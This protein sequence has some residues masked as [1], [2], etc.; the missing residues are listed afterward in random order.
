MSRD[1]Q[2]R[3]SLGPLS[4]PGGRQLQWGRADRRVRYDRRDAARTRNTDDRRGFLEFQHAVKMLDMPL[5]SLRGRNWLSPRHFPFGAEP[6]E[7]VRGPIRREQNIKSRPTRDSDSREV[8]GPAIASARGA[9][10]AQAA[11]AAMNELSRA[12]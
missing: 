5:M 11:V 8:F 7:C 6:R 1:R 12:Q 3:P 9:A 10:R 4:L 2:V